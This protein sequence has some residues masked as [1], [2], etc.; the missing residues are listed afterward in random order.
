[1][2]CYLLILSV[3]MVLTAVPPASAEF[4]RYT[5]K[6][7]NVMYTDDLSRVPADQREQVQSYEES[8]SAPVSTTRQ[9]EHQPPAEE[10]EAINEQK[11]FDQLKQREKTLQSEYDELKAEYDRLKKAE[12]EAVTPAQRKEHNVKVENFNARFQT[13]EKKRKALEADFNAY[14]KKITAKQSTKKKE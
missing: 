2:K 11:E 12:Q 3:L 6:H 9:E 5:D 13:Y 8:Q 1:M 4:Y 10:Q 14:D 7:G